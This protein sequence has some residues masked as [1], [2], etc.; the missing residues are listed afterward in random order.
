M[1]EGGEQLGVPF[2]DP[3]EALRTREGVGD[4]GV[5][6]VGVDEAD[7]DIEPL[8]MTG[9]PVEDPEEFLLHHGFFGGAGELRREG[10]KLRGGGGEPA[11]GRVLV[12]SGQGGRI[13]PGG[14][15]VGTDL[16]NR[17]VAEGAE[18]GP[19]LLD[20][21]EGLPGEEVFQGWD[22]G[23]E[24]TSPGV[25]GVTEGISGDDEGR[26]EEST[27]GAIAPGAP[28]GVGGRRCGEWWGGRRRPGGGGQ[29]RAPGRGRPRGH[30]PAA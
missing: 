21:G 3:G 10:V 17:P 26:E 25:L 27:E 23:I 16:G 11:G 18:E 5:G 20:L 7:E 12:R 8:I 14:E 22:P 29:R 30:D 2:G 9:T 24:T 28:G 1:T 19:G 6:G 4:D 13:E 15:V